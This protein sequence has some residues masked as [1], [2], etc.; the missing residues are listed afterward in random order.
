M[1]GSLEVSAFSQ[2]TG[3]LSGY[4]SLILS[5]SFFLC[6]IEK[7]GVKE[8]EYVL[9]EIRMLMLVLASHFFL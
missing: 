5:A 7:M 8:L 1:S 9:T 6:S 3:I 4:L 2:I